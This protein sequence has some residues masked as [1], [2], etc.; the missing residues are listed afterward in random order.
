M[1]NDVLL[2][3]LRIIMEFTFELAAF[4]VIV[5]HFF[6]R[7]KHTIPRILL[8]LAFILVV[9]FGLSFFYYFFGNTV[10]GRVLVYFTIFFAFIVSSKFVFNEQIVPIVFSLGM[11]Y[12][13]QNIIEPIGNVILQTIPNQR[14]T[15]VKIS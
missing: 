2:I 8:S 3:F 15:F 14:H 7:Y 1:I 9:G 12:A 6:D 10:W 5:F 11:A 4:E 13:I